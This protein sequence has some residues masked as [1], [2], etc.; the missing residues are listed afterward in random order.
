MA[1]PQASF[2]QRHDLETDFYVYFTEFPEVVLPDK[3]FSTLRDGHAILGRDSL[4]R[5]SSLMM[6]GFP[7]REFR[8]EQAGFFVISRNVVVGNRAISIVVWSLSHPRSIEE[9]PA[10]RRF[11][12]SFTL[13]PSTR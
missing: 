4:R 1:A 10:V 8:F 9:N 5:D 3:W 2:V 6:N 13:L 12:N 7:V 11:L